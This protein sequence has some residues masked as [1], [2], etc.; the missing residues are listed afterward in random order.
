MKIKIANGHLVDPTNN[1]DEITSVF[2]DDGRILSIGDQP[3]DFVADEEIEAK[4]QYVFPGLVDICTRLREPG[5]EH[6]ATI[7]SETKAAAGGGITMM[8]CPPDTFPIIDTPAM[9]HMIQ[10]RAEDSGY[11]RVRPQGA[12]TLGLKGERLTDMAMLI[13][14]GCVGVSNAHETM[15]NTL[16]M[17]RAMQ[18]ASTYD[19]PVFLTPTD[20]W[21]LGNGVVH[22]GAVSTRLGLP[23]IPEAAETVG[24]ARD[25]AL[26]ETSGVRA[27]FEML[28]CGRSVTMIEEARQRGLPV[29]A[30]VSVHQLLFTE[31][32]IGEFDTRYK[33]MPP[34]RTISDKQSLLDGIASGHI[35]AICSDHQPHG[36]DS[37]LAPFSEAATGIAG[38]D[39]L[40]TLT[41][42]LVREDHFTLPTAIAALTCNPAKII[43]TDAGHLSVGAKADLCIF[44]PNHQWI[45]NSE[46]ML[47][48]GRNSPLVDQELQG[49]VVRTLLEGKTTFDLLGNA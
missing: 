32:N 34:L 16:V 6:K 10:N 25:L 20:P 1:I 8:V 43:D 5:E 18:Y 38:L 35:D 48:R 45:L 14:A 24:V 42:K 13:D 33:V 44:D 15:Q 26:I 41:Y 31:N 11:A 9:A 30:S 19:I 7:A 37:K 12:L 40:L 39:T 28:S 36:A 29:T 17:R 22:E 27:H 21:L 49:K 2:I 46:S 4:N 23:A 47:S 3:K